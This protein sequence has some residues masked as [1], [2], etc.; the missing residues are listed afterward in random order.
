[1]VLGVMVARRFGSLLRFRTFANLAVA[2]LLMWVAASQFAKADRLPAVAYA[3]CL[4]VYGLTLV[5]LREVRR[6]DFE[7]LAFWR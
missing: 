4:A 7:L 1:M 6:K 5:S 3:G 2:T